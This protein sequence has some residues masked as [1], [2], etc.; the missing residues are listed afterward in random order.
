MRSGLKGVLFRKGMVLLQFTLSIFLIIGTLI[1][2]RQ[3]DYMKNKDIGY[4]KEHVIYIPIRGNVGSLYKT[5]KQEWQKDPKISG[6][7]GSWQLPSNNTANSG[8]AR[9]EGQ[10][11]SRSY[12]IG[13]NYVAFDFIETMK[14][15]MLEGRSFTRDF[16]SDTTENFIVNEEVVKLMGVESAEGKSLSF[17]GRSGTI[18]GVMKNFHYTSVRNNI[19]PLVL[20]ASPGLLN[21]I[22]VKLSAGNINESIRAMENIWNRVVAEYPFDFRFLDEDL[23]N[24]YMTETRLAELLKYFTILA[25]II[26]SL[27]LF[28]LAS[29]TAQ[30]RTREIGIRKVLGASE[31]KITMQ[32]CGEFL[33]LVLV[34]NAIAWPIAWLS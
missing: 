4:D 1:V 19:E 29:F 5:L 28:G 25:I 23:N 17:Q 9:W 34:A 33:L 32:L 11:Q 27:G 16:P 24:M 7:T 2:Y 31:S 8:G 14:I 12:L 10:D 13:A 6:V 26:A 21:F 22:I 18:V 15:T 3:L 20:M 30:Q